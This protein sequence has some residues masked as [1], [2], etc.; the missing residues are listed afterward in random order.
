MEWRVAVSLIRD[1]QDF[2]QRHA[3]VGWNIV[4]IVKLRENPSP[5]DDVMLLLMSRP[6][7]AGLDI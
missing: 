1:L 5:D 3:D 6:K 7:H 2:I 4:S